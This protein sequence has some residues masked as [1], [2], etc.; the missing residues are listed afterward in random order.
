[1]SI[2]INYKKNSLKTKTGNFIFF[3]D[4]KYNLSG[5]KEYFNKN[6]SDFLNDVLKAN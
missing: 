1:M 3:L 2:V 6:E 4:E 5:L